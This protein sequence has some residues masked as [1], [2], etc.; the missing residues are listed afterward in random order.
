MAD[1]GGIKGLNA[2]LGVSRSLS[3]RAWR[4]RPAEPETTRAHMQAHGLDEP[5]ARALAKKH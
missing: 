5:L 4:M 3:G 1:D 2:F